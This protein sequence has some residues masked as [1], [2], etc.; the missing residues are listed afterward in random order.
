MNSLKSNGEDIKKISETDNISGSGSNPMI[1]DVDD[2]IMRLCGSY[3][4]YLRLSFFFLDQFDDV[5]SDLRKLMD[6][7]AMDE[8]RILA[9]SLNGASANI[10]A[11]RVRQLAL[12]LEEGLEKKDIAA[13]YGFLD[14]LTLALIEVFSA[15]RALPPDD[16]RGA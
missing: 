12:K 16:G 11:L 7:G 10:S 13:S 14:E 9:H 4:F 6:K 2:G 3:D 8:A 15:I 1:L 5:S